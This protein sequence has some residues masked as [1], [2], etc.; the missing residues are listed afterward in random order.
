MTFLGRARR[1]LV[2]HPQ[3]DG[4]RLL[5]ERLITLHESISPKLFHRADQRGGA[6]ELL[7]G[8]QAQGVAHDHGQTARTVVAAEL[9]LQTAD[10]H[11]E[12]RHAQIGFGLAAAG[13]EPQQIGMGFHRL[14]AVRMRGVG[15][16]RDRQQQ[17]R[18]LERTPAPV[19]R[20]VE[21]IHRHVTSTPH[22]ERVLASHALDRHRPVGEAESSQRLLVVLQR[23]DA[24]LQT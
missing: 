5:A 10:R 9:A 11:R 22:F 8:Q 15:Q 7:Q 21:L 24:L 16:R 19:L 2:A 4:E 6:L 18:Q 20:L 23:V 14:H 13:G 17:E 3:S 12:R 1:H